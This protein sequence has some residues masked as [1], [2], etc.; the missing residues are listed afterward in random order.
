[1]RKL[2]REDHFYVFNSQNQSVIAI[3]Q[4]ER[5]AIETYDTRGGRLTRGEE[6]MSSAPNWNDE[7]PKTCPCTGPIS[8]QGVRAGDVIKISIHSID[9][10]SRGFVILKD[11]M[12]ICK[13]MV[14]EPVAMFC[15]LKDGHIKLDSS[16]TIPLRP[17]IGTI[18]TT[19]YSQPVGTAF[20]GIHGGNLD[21]PFIEAGSEVYLP[22]FVDGALL[23][24]GDL[25]A[26]MGE[27]ELMGCGVEICGTVELSVCSIPLLQLKRPVIRSR[28]KILS[29][30]RDRD[31]RTA[32][33]TASIDMIDLLER[34]GDLSRQAALALLTTV[35]DV[36][37]CQVCDEELD[38]VAAIAIDESYLH[39][40]E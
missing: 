39:L 30:A 1:M 5:I 2:S 13:Q 25:H 37:V 40:P 28:S 35:A 9:V 33:Q 4:N 38:A 23:G 6:V 20:A 18:G 36:K 3:D 32:I 7:V 24:V 34:Y 15:E 16:V 19:P 29:L 31:V 27:G 21:C 14:P 8:I 22:V 11:S 12:G 17:H 26:S 10:A